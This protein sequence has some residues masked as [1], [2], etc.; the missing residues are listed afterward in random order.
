[1]ATTSNFSVLILTHN[2]ELDLAS[3]LQ[4]VARSNDIVVLDSFSDDKTEEVAQTFGARF[5]QRLF[6]DFSD[7]RNYGLHEISFANEF[8]LLL[9]ADEM[10]SENLIH[11]ILELI[12]SERKLDD[13]YFVR[14]R[15]LFE[16]KVLKWN[17]TAGVWV[18][19]LVRPK[20]VEF[21]GAVHEKLKY[22][23]ANGH[24]S[25]YIIHNQ[26][27]KGLKRFYDRRLSYA[28]IESLGNLRSQS[29]HI[30][31]QNSISRRN[32]FK[33]FLYKYIPFLWLIY[34]IY[35]FVVKLAFLD[36][37][38]GIK[39]ILIESHSLYLTKKNL[40][41]VNPSQEAKIFASIGQKK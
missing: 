7:Q 38:K 17:Y 27:S 35:N 26:F 3:C 20:R 24:L 12:E 21:F 32:R 23:G 6:T 41:N 16:G 15:V 29:S 30:G 39:Y 13:V 1:M 22:Q 9:D 28:A 36:G 19:R 37:L 5:Y 11:E 10:A 4:S 34:F 18:E 40:S 25:N 8:V 33:S 14:R 31:V 2:E